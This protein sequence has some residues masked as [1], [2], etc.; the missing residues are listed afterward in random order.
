MEI[1]KKSPKK[2]WTKYFSY[3]FIIAI[4]IAGTFSF[5]YGVGKKGIDLP[6]PFVPTKVLNTDSGKPSNVDFSTFWEAWNKLNADSV[7]DLNPQDLVYGA[8]SGMLGAVNDPY[9]VYLKPDEN[10]RFMEDISGEFEGIGVEITEING[11]LTVV[12]PLPDSPAEKAGIKAKDVILEVDG[13]KASDLGFEATIDKIRGKSGTSVEIL[14][15]RTGAENIKISVTREKI[16]VPSVTYE[17][18]ESGGKRFEVVTLRQ[19][20]DDTNDLFDK[21]A[22]DIDKNKPDGVIID[23][24]NNPGGYLDTAVNIASYLID[25][26]VIV[27]EVEKN[28]QKKDVKTVR[29]AT[30]KN[31]PL[32]LLVNEGSA[33]ASE[34]LA[35]AVKDRGRGKIIGSKTFGKGSVQILENLSDNSAVK[36]TIAKWLTP[37][38]SQINKTGIQ[39]DIEVADDPNSDSDPVLNKAFETLN[40]K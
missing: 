28:N 19:F 17:I 7:D 27:S 11:E 8:I 10:K 40:N 3:F 21:A 29:R 30:L 15:K 36:I 14:L 31:Y 24:R 33:S 13:K 4:V 25:G 39:P 16:K 22:T 9:T 26:G 18:K 37:N 12:A 38:G 20:G 23:L 5:G 2:I 35:G 34:I 32:V 1:R 6:V